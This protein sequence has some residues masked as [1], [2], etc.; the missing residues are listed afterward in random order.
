M[1]YRIKIK[2]PLL[3]LSVAL[4]DNLYNI[5]VYTQSNRKMYQNLM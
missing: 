4:E 1:G 5:T 2:Y 3:A